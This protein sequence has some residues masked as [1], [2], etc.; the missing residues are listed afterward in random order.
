MGITLAPV[1]GKLVA[2]MVLD[3]ASPPELEPFRIERFLR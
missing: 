1:T 3:G 2:G